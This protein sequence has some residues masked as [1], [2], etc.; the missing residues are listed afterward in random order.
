MKFLVFGGTGFIGSNLVQYIRDQ[1]GEVFPV[2]RSGGKDSLPLDITVGSEFSKINFEPDVVINCASRIPAKGKKSTDPEFLKELFLTNVVGAANIANWAVK[3]EILKLI[4]CSTLVVVN[5]PWPQP[6]TEDYFRLPEG[7]HAGYAMSKL[8]QEQIMNHCVS[9][10]DTRLIHMRLSAV[11]GPG[12]TP[13]G[14]IFNLLKNLVQDRDVN[15]T[16][17]NSNSL[18]LIHVKDVCKAIYALGVNGYEEKVMN[19]A[20]GK[21]VSIAQLAERLKEITGSNSK[22]NNSDTG[23]PPSRAVIDIE[24]LKEH[25]GPVYADFVPLKEG[26]KQ[27]TGNFSSLKPD[28]VQ[29]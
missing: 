18:D 1:G 2:S 6:L 10:S 16:D 5:K 13:E 27:M 11:Y 22:I 7:F 12:M 20:S 29:K 17:A 23:N 25:I 28:Q 3:N 19:L 14:I 9:G 26:L 21:E 4:N 24:R 8:S 15:L